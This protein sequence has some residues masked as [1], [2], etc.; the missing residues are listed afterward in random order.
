M[1]FK[2]LKVILT[3]KMPN[4]DGL[5]NCG[6]YLHFPDYAVTLSS[7]VL[8]TF[9]SILPVAN[10]EISSDPLKAAIQ[11]TQLRVMGVFRDEVAVYLIPRE[12]TQEECQ[13]LLQN[14]ER[15]AH[16]Y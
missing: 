2:G 13:Q 14:T 10:R 7:E 1:N 5:I 3:E 11:L 8:V 9:A 15:A 16:G 4:K 6:Y 12:L